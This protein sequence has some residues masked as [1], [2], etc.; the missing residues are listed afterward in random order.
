M[1]FA[2]KYFYSLSFPVNPLCLALALL[3]DA[4]RA[5]WWW[6]CVHAIRVLLVLSHQPPATKCAVERL[7]V[8]DR[9]RSLEGAVCNDKRRVRHLY[10]SDA[11]ELV[12]FVQRTSR[13]SANSVELSAPVS[14][15]FIIRYQS[16]QDTAEQELN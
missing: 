8:H 3:D 4:P 6:W 13:T 11:N 12:V 7:V 10:T 2:V 15:A 5:E 14:P 16:T 9:N 1:S